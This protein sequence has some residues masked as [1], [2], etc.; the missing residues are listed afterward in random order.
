MCYLCR[1]EKSNIRT[2]KLSFLE[3][4]LKEEF[5]QLLETK[6]PAYMQALFDKEKS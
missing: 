3:Q 2:E 4:R 1:I 6:G 5:F